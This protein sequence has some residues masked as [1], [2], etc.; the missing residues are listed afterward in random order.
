MANGRENVGTIS[1]TYKVGKNIANVEREDVTAK[2]KA[3]AQRKGEGVVA[4]QEQFNSLY[5]QGTLLTQGT[6]DPDKIL[7]LLESDALSGDFGFTYGYDEI[8]GQFDPTSFL[9]AYRGYVGTRGE[10]VQQSKARSRTF[11][12]GEI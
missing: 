1:T 3:S 11:L 9:K 12:T 2:N 4:A 8:L 5:G 10:Q 7:E 6:E